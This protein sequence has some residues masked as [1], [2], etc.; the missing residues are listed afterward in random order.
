MDQ[1]LWLWEVRTSNREKRVKKVRMSDMHD[2]F[3]QA[4]WENTGKSLQHPVTSGGPN[5]LRRLILYNNDNKN[6]SLYIVFLGRSY[7]F[8]LLSQHKECRS[9]PHLQPTISQ[10]GSVSLQLCSISQLGVKR[11]N[12]ISTLT[13]RAHLI[14]CINFCCASN[15]STWNHA[16]SSPVWRRKKI[17]LHEDL[18]VHTDTNCK[19]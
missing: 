6:N 10:F 19:E 14:C 17:T 15:L 3:Y 4:K 18:N 5:Q 16:T 9:P 8:C 11:K 13:Q 7:S 12:E 1:E 2:Y